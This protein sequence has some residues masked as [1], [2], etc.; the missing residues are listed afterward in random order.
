MCSNLF[1]N[2]DINTRSTE[3]LS[4]PESQAELPISQSARQ[5]LVRDYWAKLRERLCP[6]EIVDR[7]FEEDILSDL[8]RQ[9][10]RDQT[11]TFKQIDILL[12]KV[13]RLSNVRIR[14][15]AQVLSESHG[16]D[17]LGGKMLRDMDKAREDV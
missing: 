15:F 16:I 14:Y 12:E 11:A 17:D 8:D 6:L 7:L 10:I 3:L 1:R 13:K 9:Q 5:V 2:N 4:V